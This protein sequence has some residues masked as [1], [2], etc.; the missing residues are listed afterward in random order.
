NSCSGGLTA[1]KFTPHMISETWYN[2]NANGAPRLTSLSESPRKNAG[3]NWQ[4]L[5]AFETIVTGELFF[6]SCGLGGENRSDNRL[7]ERH[8]RA[9]AGA[10]LFDGVLLFGFALGKKVRAAG[11]VFG[12]PFLGEAAV[13]NFSK[14]LSHFVARL[15]RDDSRTG[16][17]IAMFSGVTDGIAHV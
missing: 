2:G 10:E 14:K 6:G 7:Q 11:F 16:G 4:I 1:E 9:Q 5:P 3:K 15:L 12:N 13:A 17:V 8:H